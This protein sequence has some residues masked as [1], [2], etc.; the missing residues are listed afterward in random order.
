MVVR[1]GKHV[2]GSTGVL[3]VAISASAGTVESVTSSPEPAAV[4]Q[5]T[6]VNAARTRVLQKHSGRTVCSSASVEPAAPAIG[7]QENVFAERALL[8]L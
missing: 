1:S 7:R 2:T 8:E 6:L 3:A 5:D 4:Q